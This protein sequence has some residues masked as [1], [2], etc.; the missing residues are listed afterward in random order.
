M[1]YESPKS[2]NSKVMSKV[3]V[4]LMKVKGHRQDHEVKNFRSRKSFV[5]RNTHVKYES[6]TSYRS[7][8]MSKVKVFKMYIK[9]NNQ[10]QEVKIFG[11]D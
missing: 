5:T 1:K 10:G 9:G 3:K 8:V 2:Y 4:F 7:K 11:T 6:P